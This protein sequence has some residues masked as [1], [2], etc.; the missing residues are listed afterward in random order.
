M[1]AYLHIGLRARLSVA[2]ASN[3]A[4]TDKLKKLLAAEIDLSLYDEQETS[5]SLI[6]SLKPSLVEQELVP[7]LRKQF[8]LIPD[9]HETAS[10]EKMLTELQGVKTLQDLEDWSDASDSFVGRW[11]PY[12]S[13]MIREGRDYHDVSVATFVFLSEGKISMEECGSILDY[14]E[15]LIALSNPEFLIAKAASVSI[16]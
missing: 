8:N 9:P 6:W 5:N 11:N 10:R 16:N 7:F 4:Q 3:S 2:K 1:G 14:F 15:R 12:D 13:F